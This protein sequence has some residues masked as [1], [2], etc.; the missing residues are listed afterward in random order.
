M[1]TPESTTPPAL[2]QPERNPEKR[3]T[4]ENFSRYLEAQLGLSQNTVLSYS[5]AL[6]DFERWLGNPAVKT[7]R[8]Q[9]Y[10]Y[11][12]ALLNQQLSPQTVGHRLSVLRT[13]F[14]F[15]LDRNLVRSD[16]THDMR[17]PKRP[18][19]LPERPISTSEVRKMLGAAGRRTAKGLR[20][21]VI[22]LLGFD[23]TGNP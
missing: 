7:K 6:T 5:S 12:A 13:F 9:I 21:R 14:A 23:L 10:S 15:A 19:K 1:A 8:A 3:S 22:L 16:P 11:L 2:A 20:A 18:Q 17:G 4:I